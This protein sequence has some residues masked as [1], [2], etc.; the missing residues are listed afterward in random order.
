MCTSIR[1]KYTNEESILVYK[2]R[3]LVYKENTD[4]RVCGQGRHT[5]GTGAATP[6]LKC[7]GSVLGLYG[8]FDIGLGKPKLFRV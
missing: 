8:A 3:I 5:R 2:E 1:R 6:I 7:P 4:V